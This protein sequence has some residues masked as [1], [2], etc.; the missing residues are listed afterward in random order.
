MARVRGMA[1]LGTARYVKHNHGQATLDR[2]VAE[3]GPATQKT[4]TKR[5][6]GL[7]L[8]PYESFAGFLHSTDRVLGTG[9]LTFCRRIGEMAARNDLQTIFRVYAVRPSPETMIRACTPVWGMY[10]DDAG[11][12]EAVEVEPENTVLRITDFPDMDPAHCRLMEG[13][14]SAAM[15]V[16]GARVLP[17]SGETE[18]MSQ[19]GRYHEFCCRWELKRIA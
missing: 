1:F 12:M 11:Y 4:F 9:D 2:I 8:Q 7:G 16:I 19:G 10:Y 15:D 5:I 6:D 17:G 3:A 18:C 14:M 13:W